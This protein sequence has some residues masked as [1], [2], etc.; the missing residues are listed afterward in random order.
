MYLLSCLNHA[1]H[2]DIGYLFEAS[3]GL[4]GKF[5]EMSFDVDATVFDSNNK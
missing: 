4:T 1:H 3:I 2:N 5:E